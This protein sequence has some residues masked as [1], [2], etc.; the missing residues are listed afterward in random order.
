MNGQPDEG[1]AMIPD[2]NG[3]PWPQPGPPRLQRP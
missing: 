3:P 1:D 2:R